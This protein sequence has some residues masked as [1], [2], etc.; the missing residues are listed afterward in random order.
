MGKYH[1]HGEGAI[2]DS[3]V[4]MAQDFSL[5]HPLVDGHGNFGSPD[6]GPAASRYCLVGDTRIRLADGSSPRIADVVDLPASSEREVDGL[7]VLDKDGKSVRVDRLFNSGV[8][9]TKRI[10]TK[11]GFSLRGTHNHPI[12]CLEPVAGVPMF[13]WHTLDEIKPGVV[14]ALARNAWMQV[15]P[16]AREFHLGVL[17]GAWVSEGWASDTRAGFNNTDKGFFDDVAYAYGEMV[18]GRFYISE[19]QSAGTASASSSSTS[20]TLSSFASA[21]SPS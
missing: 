7:T 6:F 16:T 18:G 12:L 15:V 21:H 1:P 4:R 9:P 3:L 17:C 10:T 19:R 8:H 2:Y 14:V 11:L 5:R 20:R 13:Q